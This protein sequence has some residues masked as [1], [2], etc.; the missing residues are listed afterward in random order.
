V[1]LRDFNF[2]GGVSENEQMDFRDLLQV[3]EHSQQE[4]SQQEHSQQ[5]QQQVPQQLLL[6][7]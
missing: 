2:Y 5:E 3:W 7:E 4:H 6:E 1:L